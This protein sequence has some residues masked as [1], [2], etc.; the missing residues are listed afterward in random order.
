MAIQQKYEK[1][2][3]GEILNFGN[4]YHKITF[5][6]GSKEN[7]NIQITIYNDISKKY[8]LN[9]VGYRFIPKI[10]DIAPNF[11]KQG[12]EYLKT[13]D[14]YKNAIDLLEED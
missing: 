4:A 9:Q 1:K 13:L 10:E 14:E 3:Y 2:I 5:I 6:N 7:I 8:I 11:I 12:Y